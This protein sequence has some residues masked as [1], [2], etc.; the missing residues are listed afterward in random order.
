MDFVAESSGGPDEDASDEAEPRDVYFFFSDRA[1]AARALRENWPDA[2]GT[3]ITEISLFDLL[4]RWLPG[5][6]DDGH[7]AGTN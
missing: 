6:N 2:P 1:Y 4:Y 7:L 5:L 3:K